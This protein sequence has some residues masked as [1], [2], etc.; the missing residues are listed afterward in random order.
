MQ[1]HGQGGG[2]LQSMGYAT[3]SL[4]VEGETKN[5]IQLGETPISEGC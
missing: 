3:R 1:H 4:S 2:V 5:S